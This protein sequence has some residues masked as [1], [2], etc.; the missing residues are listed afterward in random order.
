M[1][2]KGRINIMLIVLAIVSALVL[3]YLMWL[4][5]LPPESSIQRSEAVQTDIQTGALQGQDFRTLQPYAQL[6]IIPSN[7][8]RPNPFIPLPNLNENENGNDNENTNAITNLLQGVR[9]G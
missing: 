6:P 1:M 4:F 9:G 7:I 8:G 5:L 3:G 2:S